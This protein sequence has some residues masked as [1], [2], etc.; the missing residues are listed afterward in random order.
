M[1]LFVKQLVVIVITQKETRL[2]WRYWNSNFPD[3][4]LDYSGLLK[5][6]Y[7]CAEWCGS[8]GLCE[9][10]SR[11]DFEVQLLDWDYTGNF[12]LLLLWNHAVDALLND[13]ALGYLL[14]NTIFVKAQYSFC[15]AIMLLKHVQHTLS[16]CNANWYALLLQLNVIRRFL[17]EGFQTHMQV[18]YSTSTESLQ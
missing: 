16:M 13:V 11:K 2:L 17:G 8:P 14:Y 4:K 15:N 3:R 1:P 6:D 9:A 12:K 10:A 5:M 18:S 7:C